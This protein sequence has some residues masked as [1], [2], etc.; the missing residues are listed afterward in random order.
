MVIGL[1]V[2]GGEAVGIGAGGDDGGLAHVHNAEVCRGVFRVGDAH[3]PERAVRLQTQGLH[4]PAHGD[5][6]ALHTRL[7]HGVDSVFAG[8]ALRY[9]GKGQLRPDGKRHRIRPRAGEAREHQSVVAELHHLR[10]NLLVRGQIVFPVHKAP[11]LDERVDR[12]IERAAALGVDRHRRGE[13]LCHLSRDDHVLAVGV[14][15]GVSGAVGHLGVKPRVHCD[16]NALRR[17]QPGFRLLA[18][19]GQR[20]DGVHG[21]Q[22]P[23]LH[24]GLPAG[25]E[26]EDR[27]Q[28]EQQRQHDFIIDP[29]ELHKILCNPSACI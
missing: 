27:A 22:L 19:S 12:Q 9:G 10:G 13:H 29:C 11:A 24:L 5:K 3:R 6:G 20:H 14:V 15:D 7:P 21:G 8:A 2:H 16:D 4:V 28:R 1:A 26:G 18:V 23:L 17:P 25:G